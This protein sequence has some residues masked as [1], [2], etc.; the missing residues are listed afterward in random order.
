MDYKGMNAGVTLMLPVNEPG[1]LFFLG[2][3]HARQ[4]DGEVTGGAIETSLD[5]EFSVDVIKG[6]KINWPRW[7][8]NDGTTSWCWGVRGR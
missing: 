1:A 3:V 2:D 4:G 7:L 8:E 5:V 6:K